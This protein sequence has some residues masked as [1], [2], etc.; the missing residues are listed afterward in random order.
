VD[1]GR[2]KGLKGGESEVFEFPPLR[3]EVKKSEVET[4]KGGEGNRGKPA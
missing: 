4:E 3:G 2:W 1:L